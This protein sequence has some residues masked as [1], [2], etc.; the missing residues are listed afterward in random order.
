MGGGAFSMRRE[1]SPVT[2]R[3]PCGAR[4]GGPRSA[5]GCC[6]QNSFVSFS[7]S[8]GAESI[9]IWYPRPQAAESAVP[10]VLETC[11]WTGAAMPDSI[12]ALLRLI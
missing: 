10:E 2:R 4:G 11:W 9:L 1:S 5:E 12:G 7:F 3:G 8:G 6:A